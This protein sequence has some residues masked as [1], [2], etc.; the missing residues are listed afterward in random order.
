MLKV[1]LIGHDFEYEIFELLRSYYNTEN[2][3]FV[4]E[5]TDNDLYIE[6]ILKQDIA[7]AI[8]TCVYKDGSL[9]SRETADYNEFKQFKD[10]KKKN[11]TLIKKSLL[12]AILKVNTKKAP[13]GIL[14]GIRPT[15]IV[16]TLMDDGKKDTEIL[17]ILTDEYMIASEKAKLLVDVCN[18]ERQYLTEENSKKYSL[19]V[20]IPFCP[21]RCVYC[22]FPSNSIDKFKDYTDRYVDSVIYELAKTY[23]IMKSKE[24]YTVYIGGG[25]PTALSHE[26]LDRIIKFIYSKF[27]EGIKEFTVEA[28]RPDTISKEILNMLKQNKIDRI[29]INPQTMC[30]DTL[31]IIGRKHT[32]S[33]IIRAFDMAR[34]Y[35]FNNINMDLIVGLPGENISNVERTMDLIYN[36]KPSNLTVHTLAIKRA[37]KLKSYLDKYPLADGKTIEKMLEITQNWTHKMGMKPYYMYRQKQMLGNFENVG[38][39]IK[40]KECIYNIMI[41]EER[42]SIIA[43]GAGAVSKIVDIEKNQITRVPNVKDLYEYLNRVDEMVKR[44]EK[45]ITKEL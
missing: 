16:H 37:S 34:G 18:Q 7:P 35:G 6:S 30:D 3:K 25:T 24:L 31:S 14:T 19:Y 15:K 5:K 28:G 44:K 17:A 20:S 42:Q 27:G 23:E 39:S 22:S 10:L 1:R 41:M 40:D 29:S 33:D 26:Q 21:T 36:L 9:I 12:N 11:K 45:A 2:I 4:D 38:Y 8:I 43:V 13:W 32:S